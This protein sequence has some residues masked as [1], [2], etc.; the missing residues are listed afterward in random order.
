MTNVQFRSIGLSLRTEVS[1]RQAEDPD[2]TRAGTA[3]GEGSE[4][5]RRTGGNPE[6][7][8]LCIP[9]CLKPSYVLVEPRASLN[10]MEEKLGKLRL[11][12]DLIYV[13]FTLE[14]SH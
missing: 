11:V 14:H 13:L 5:S 9:T 8:L 4:R 7:R 2:G 6:A 10:S 3:R 1:G 12:H